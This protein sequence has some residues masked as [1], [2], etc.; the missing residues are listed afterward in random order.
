MSRYTK[1]ITTPSLQ[2]LFNVLIF[3]C[4]FAPPLINFLPG[5]QQ[6]PSTSDFHVLQ[7]NCRSLNTNAS[8][9]TQFLFHSQIPY[10]AV[11]LQSV[12]MRKADLPVLNNYFYP[13]FYSMEENKIRTAIYVRKFFTVNFLKPIDNVAS[14]ACEIK[15]SQTE[16]LK[17]YNVY[18]PNG[19]SDQ[20]TR[21]ISDLQ[22][23]NILLVGDF[24]A[25]HAM[26]GGT[27]TTTS[28]GGQWLHDHVTQSNLCL[29]NDGSFTH[30]P[31]RTDQRPSIIDLSFISSEL[32]FDSDWEAIGDPLGSD[33]LPL[34]ITISSLSTS[35]DKSEM[36]YNYTKADWPAF[37]G[38]LET[39]N[40]N[41]IDVNASIDDQYNCFRNIVIAAAD[42]AIPKKQTRKETK[43]PPNPWW[44][45][46]CL[47]AVRIKR[48]AYKR[49]KRRQ[50]ND[51]HSALKEARINCKRV[52]AKAKVAYWKKYL[53]DNVSHYSDAKILFKHVRKIRWRYCPAEKPLIQNGRKT[54]SDKE[55]SEVLADQF[56]KASRS[57]Y[58]PKSSKT[59]R[60]KEDNKR[61]D[62]PNNPNCPLNKIFGLSEMKLCIKGILNNK[63][64]TGSD[65]ISYRM[66]QHFPDRT[67]N[68]MLSIFNRCWQA[69]T[70]PAAWKQATVVA[71]PKAGKPPSNPSSYRPISLTPHLGKL[72]ERMV[73]SRLEY[74]LQ[75]NNIIPVLQAG[76][77]QGRGC[78]DNAV[79][80]SAHV[81]KALAKRRTTLAAFYDVHRAYDTV[82]HGRLLSKLADIG[83]TGNMFNFCKTFLTGRSFVVK[84]GN[85]VSASK[86]VDM[87]VPQG[88]IIAPTF[89]NVMLYDIN[90]V[91]LKNAEITLYADD[92][93][94]FSTEDYKNLKSDY[95]KKVIMKRFQFN[96]N[97]LVQYMKDN[98]FS[99][100]AEK[101]VFMIFNRSRFNPNDYFITI[102][103]NKIHPS[104]EVKYLGIVF[105]KQ[106]TW[107]SHIKHNIEKTNHVWSLLKI[108]KRTEG[109]NDVK[110]LCHV[111]QSLIRSRLLY[112]H[113]SFFSASKNV[114]SKLQT[115]ECKFLRYILGMKNCVPQEVVYRETGLLPL[116]YEIQSRTAQYIYRA[117]SVPNSTDIE[118]DIG[119]DN[120]NETRQQQNL[121]KTPRVNS[122]M[123]SVANYAERI[124]QEIKINRTDVAKL[125]QYPLP[126]WEL[127]DLD[128]KDSLGDFNKDDH[129]NVLSSLAIE[130]I[131]TELQEY[132]CIY[133][134]G[135][136]LDDDKVGCAFYIP[137]LGVTKSFRLNDGVSIM[138]AEM[139][140]ILMA[141]TYCNDIDVCI[142]N[143]AILSDSKSSLQAMNSRSKNRR[144]MSLEIELIVNQLSIK[145]NSVKF[146]WIPSHSGILG[147]D[148]ADKAAKDG[149]QLPSV[150]YNVKFSVSEV[151]CKI[152]NVLHNEW[153][154]KYHD[155]SQNRNW[156]IQ[157]V[158]QV[159]LCP[160][161][162]RY[163]IPIFF[164]LRG[165][166]FLTQYSTQHC[167][168]GDTL[169]YNHIFTCQQIIPNMPQVTR[170]ALENGIQPHTPNALLTKHP[171]LGWRLTRAFIHDLC[172]SGIGHLV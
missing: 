85:S 107:S 108:L 56:A 94:L 79:K 111:V 152:K 24:N 67:L 106:L 53:N 43:Y 15:M 116:S 19:C 1:P 9:L 35:I 162:P 23:E 80:L 139:F 137:K 96:V 16:S 66:I 37:V 164:R 5:M 115:A 167:T 48:R 172:Q 28:R 170:L 130:M 8:Q 63:K 73:K 155:L 74:H 171:I 98:G 142:G 25:H 30:I 95:V 132:T 40:Y 44:T 20:D 70:V 26:W 77:Q 59:Y 157:D 76:F 146:Q 64:A 160:D 36:K 2:V 52:I 120:L 134:D 141:L 78:S 159:D 133:T 166:T 51:T 131:N 90:K 50:N 163:Q 65:P 124:T 21:W 91:K 57:E 33:H 72:Y 11:C 151:T 45:L 87:G 144:E 117:S 68:V 118:L 102:D 34:K 127:V 119:F 84:I 69:G 156:I 103:N 49:Y 135:S 54:N 123:I 18:Y 42:A 149:A 153:K 147:N 145:G 14:S 17:I 97:Q 86:N 38:K 105:D 126:P 81:K 148:T 7:W 125:P 61:R 92:L 31:D 60:D 58:L 143:I 41:D 75:K 4:A 27:G 3:C 82:W 55:K 110:N 100:A 12:N 99:L 114:L 168:C 109:A 161:L 129:P 101:T 154:T 46:D 47:E 136:K 71:V 104:A 29:I 32:L 6:N 169:S 150:T 22:G 13:P 88:S 138:T 128:I 10:H 113:E 158:T 89:F 165:K 39:A 112:G 93:L 83:L 122:R 140:A 121:A 62:P